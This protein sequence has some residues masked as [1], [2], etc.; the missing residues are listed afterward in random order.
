MGRRIFILALGTFILWSAEALRADTKVSDSIDL[1]GQFKDINENEW[2]G[3]YKLKSTTAAFIAG[4][5]ISASGPNKVIYVA[6]YTSAEWAKFVALWNK[7]RATPPPP[8]HK[9]GSDDGTDVGNYFDSEDQTMA[10]LSRGSDGTIS[11]I[12]VGKDYTT[13]PVG[14][15][16]ADF[17][18]IEDAISEFTSYLNN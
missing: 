3:F 18:S 14:L 17:K 11:I 16:P 15:A 6:F 13:V 8:F 7:A 9:D 4:N 2:I 5:G 12:I 10:S 1:V